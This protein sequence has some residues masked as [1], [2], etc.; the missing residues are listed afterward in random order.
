MDG[1]GENKGIAPVILGPRHTMTIPE[2]VEL[3]G[4]QRKEVEAP[5][6][7]PFDNRAPRHFDGHCHA[8]RLAHCHAPQ[9]VRQSGQTGAIMV[10]GPLPHPATVAVKHADLMLL[11]TPINPYKP[12]VGQ[13][14]IR[15]FWTYGSR[16]DQAHSSLSFQSFSLW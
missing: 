15:S 3:F 9:P 13:R 12:L 1:I 4:I 8:L 11:R 14:L 5:F 16:H 2:A 6:E 10:H 7:P